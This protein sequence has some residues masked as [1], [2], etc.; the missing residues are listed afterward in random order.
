M[1][2]IRHLQ[3]GR[4]VHTTCY[5]ILPLLLFIPTHICC[6]CCHRRLLFDYLLLPHLTLFTL[7]VLLFVVVIWPCYIFITDWPFCWWRSCWDWFLIS[8]R[9]RCCGRIC[10]V[11]A[12]FLRPSHWVAF[13]CLAFVVHYV[14]FRYICHFHSRCVTVCCCVRTLFVPTITSANVVLPPHSLPVSTVVQS[15]I[16]RLIVLRILLL[17]YSF[18]LNDAFG[19]LLSLVVLFRCTQ[20]I[21]V[22]F[23]PAVLLL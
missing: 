1:L 2:L 9:V 4:F 12:T 22:L 15:C 8:Y 21:C 5:A 23:R 3:L 20:L 17:Q 7:L 16:T 6:W 19:T 18:D 10:C 13:C 11:R 14:A